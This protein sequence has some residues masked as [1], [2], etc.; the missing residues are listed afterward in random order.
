MRSKYSSFLTVAMCAGVTLSIAKTALGEDLASVEENS[1]QEI[2]VT[3]QRRI[4]SAQSVPIAVSAF[5]A[6]DLKKMGASSSEDLP[7]MV[8]GL[9]IQPT[10]SSQPIFLRGVGNNNNGSAVITFVDGVYFPFQTGNLLFNNVASIEVDKGPQGTLF[11][12]NATGGVVQITTR[13]PQYAPTADIEVGYGN[14]NTTTGSVYGSTGITD[15]LAADIAGYYNNQKDGWG[16]NLATGA[17]VYTSKD[18]ALRTKWIYELSDRTR[19]RFIADYSTSDGSVGTTVAPAVGRSLLFNYLTETPYTIPGRYNVDANYQPSSDARQMGASLR[20]DHDFGPVKGVSITSWRDQRTSLYIDYDGTPIPFFNLYRY[21]NRD[22]ETQEFQLLSNG[23]GKITWV[24][25]TYFYNDR[26][27]LQPFGFQGIGGHAVFGAPAGDAYNII[28]NDRV[29][30]YAVFGQTSIT[31]APDTRVTL[32]G[33]YTIDDRYI[34]GFTAGGA[35]PVPGTAGE[36]STSFKK[37]TYRLGLDHNFTPDLLAYLSYNRGFN[38]GYFNQVS[39][40]GFTPAE[41]PVVEPETIDAYEIGAKTEWFDKRLRANVSAF[42][43]QYKNLQQQV[44]E[45]AALVTVNAAAAKIKGIDLDVEA[46][47][48]HNLTLAVGFEF[49]DSKFSDYKNAPI[50]STAPNQALISLPGNASGDY[51]ANAP[52]L[53]GNVRA[54]YKIQSRVGDFDTAA[55]YSYVGAWYAD[56]GNYWRVSSHYLLNLAETW[57]SRD[58]RNH[59]TL[60]G[61]NLNNAD[62]DQGV[63]M[64]T[65]V[66]PVGNPGAPRTFGISLGH[67]F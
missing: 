8:P 50:Y 10:G 66:G 55:A 5:A 18:V 20:V 19:I 58:T 36:Q 54:N 27:R 22:A 43:Y 28:A 4:E 67:H 31:V 65:P 33:R 39:T 12:R 24:V 35:V 26:G 61:K 21:D 64:L 48:A 45:G 9:S 37:P 60:W 47:V 7:L 46:R 6:A 34:A 56:P 63:N 17:D 53:S 23:S 40:A 13:D 57:T 11:G 3:A 51:T 38:S 52:R 30:S 1:L 15:K 29:T 16:H 44:Y 2:T 42:L 14:F 32:G 59:V 25:G 41:D 62:Y 49:L